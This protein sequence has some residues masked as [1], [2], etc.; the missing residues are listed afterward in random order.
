V[1]S[2]KEPT[3]WTNLNWTK[4]LSGVLQ[5]SVLRLILFLIFINGLDKAVRKIVILKKFS[6]DTK[7]V[8]TAAN[9]EDVRNMQEV[10][11]KPVDWANTWN[12]TFNVSKCKVMHL[13][14][15]NMAN[16]YTMSG[17]ASV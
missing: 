5:G 7:I 10:T 17:Q 13:G 4:V 14:H 2:E 3:Q 12:M 16:N 11:N 9:A 8:Q 15:R 6:D 1:E